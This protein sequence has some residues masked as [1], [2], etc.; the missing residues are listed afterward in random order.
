MDLLVPP[1]HAETRHASSPTFNHGGDLLASPSDV[2]AQD[3]LEQFGRIAPFV[4]FELPG[5]ARGEDG[6]DPGPVVRFEVFGRVD[7]DEAVGTATGRRGG[8]I[9]A[10]RGGLGGYGAGLVEGFQGPGY[11]QEIC[12]GVRGQGWV[13]GGYEM[14]CVEERFD[15]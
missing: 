4:R 10:G 8:W 14:A 5:L 1:L 15:V 12:T 11:V 13:V 2:D 9:G 3:V 7:N 6:D